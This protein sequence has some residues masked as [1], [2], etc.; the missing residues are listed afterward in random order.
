DLRGRGVLHQVVD[1]GR[2]DSVEPRGDVL[3]A[4]GD[5]QA[6]PVLRDLARCGGDV[7]QIGGGNG[8][9]LSLPVDLIRSLA[10]DVVVH[11]HSN[12]NEIGVSD[13]GPVE[14]VTGLAELVLP[15]LRECDLVGV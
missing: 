5:V 14:A 13:P 1:G 9:L 15:N 4:D 6:D 8:N 12:G 3:D 10:E 7:E 2:A 11:D